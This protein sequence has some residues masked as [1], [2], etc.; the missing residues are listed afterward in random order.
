MAEAW[1]ELPN[2][3]RLHLKYST[4]TGRLRVYHMGNEMA[5][6]GLTG[7][8]AV[9]NIGLIRVEVESRLTVWATCEVTV[10]ANG[11][12]ILRRRFL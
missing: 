1:V 9:F 2:G 4:W 3:E 7:G 6:L 11:N 5:N 8:I 10:R 12:I